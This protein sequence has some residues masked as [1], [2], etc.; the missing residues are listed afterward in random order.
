MNTVDVHNQD[1]WQLPS[2]EKNH[3]NQDNQA[4]CGDA[5]H[6]QSGVDVI[7][8]NQTMSSEKHYDCKAAYVVCNMHNL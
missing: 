8:L 7:S 1:V 5:L 2:S 6:K 3:E 4:L